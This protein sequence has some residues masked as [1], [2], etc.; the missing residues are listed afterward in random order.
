MNHAATASAFL[1]DVLVA[2]LDERGAQFLREA[3]VE[4][5][6]GPSSARFGELLSAASRHARR[7]PLDLSD[8]ELGRGRS[9]ARDLDP[10]RWTLLD[11]LRVRLVLAHGGL[12]GEAGARAIEDA[13]RFADEGETI[14]LLRAVPLVPAPERFLRRVTEGCRSNMR[15]VF[16][17]AATDSP[18]PRAAFDD[19]AWRQALLKSLFVGAPLCRVRGVDERLDAE[20]ARMALD[21]ADERR[22][23]GRP[24][25][26]EL[27]LLLGATLDER[28]L[29]SLELELDSPRACARAAAVLALVRGGRTD[30]AAARV[31]AETDELAVRVGR[32]A[33]DGRTGAEAYAVLAGG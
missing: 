10:E 7:R 15:S 22:S 23:A 33:L 28:A 2:R 27:W 3:L 25:P 6:A 1:D 11:A 31:A 18:F 8:A 32:A 17:A 12:A 21:Y 14:A 13:F 19:V 24:V 30:L 9:I 4:L 26:P 29:A 5:S 20:T 16:E